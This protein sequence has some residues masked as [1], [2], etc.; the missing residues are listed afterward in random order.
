MPWFAALFSRARLS[1]KVL[2]RS[3]A[4]RLGDSLPEA[5]LEGAVDVLPGG[6]GALGD[7]REGLPEGGFV[8]G[9]GNGGLGGKLGHLLD[10][11]LV[12]PPAFRVD[13]LQDAGLLAAMAAGAGEG[14][15][16]LGK[17]RL[18]SSTLTGGFGR[19]PGPVL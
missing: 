13:A 4:H 12:G 19:W 15:G 5:L 1:R 9:V 6:A 18:A 2:S 16:Q 17:G 10:A 14:L 7:G 8:E 11:G 3:V